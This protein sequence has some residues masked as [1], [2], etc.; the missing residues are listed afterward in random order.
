VSTKANITDFFHDAK[1]RIS[2][3]VFPLAS[4]LFSGGTVCADALATFWGF[5]AVS[6]EQQSEAG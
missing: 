4:H 2:P 1:L 3:I 5:A 6:E